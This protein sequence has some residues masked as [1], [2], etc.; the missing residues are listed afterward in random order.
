[1]VGG[2][3]LSLDYKMCDS[4]LRGRLMRRDK[5]TPPVTTSDQA[6][7]VGSSLPPQATAATSIYRVKLRALMLTHNAE[8]ATDPTTRCVLITRDCDRS[9]LKSPPS[10]F[11]RIER[12]LHVA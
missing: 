6:D 9:N 11:N 5:S 4:K 12:S 2:N 7:W 1:M 10:A 3:Q 8:K